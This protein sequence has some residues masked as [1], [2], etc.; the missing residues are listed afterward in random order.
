MSTS[1]TVPGG[2]HL[3][4]KSLSR[5]SVEGE[6][7]TLELKT[8]VNLLV[9][10]PNTGK[11]SWVRA[12][13]YIFG[14]SN[15]PPKALKRNV[16]LKYDRVRAV[17][18]IDGA[19]LLLERGW[20]PDA[21]QGKV[22][23][24]GLSVDQSEFSDLFLQ[25][26]G[27]PVL[28]IPQGNPY[29]ARTWPRLSWRDLYRH[30]YRNE[31]SW[32]DIADRQP[33]S[34]QFASL[35]VLLGAGELV[36]PPDFGNLVDL[37]K[38]KLLLEG[39]KE[40]YISTLEE[41]TRDLVS[42]QEASVA[43]TPDSIARAKERVSAD[44]AS[45]EEQRGR[46]L[47]ALRES[48]D[49]VAHDRQQSRFE[50]VATDLAESR[51]ARDKL[52]TDMLALRQRI[53]ELNRLGS[54]ASGEFAKLG[55]LKVASGILADLKITHCPN[56]DQP[57]SAERLVPENH[58]HVCVQPYPISNST[59]GLERVEFEENQLQSELAELSELLTELVSEESK[60]S[61][62]IRNIDDRIR[63]LESQLAPV[64]RTAALVLP[65]ELTIID[66]ERGQLTEQARQLD[67]VSSAL[68]KRDKLAT[69]IDALNHEIGVLEAAVRSQQKDAP[70]EQLAN[71]FAMHMNEYLNALNLN[72]D[73]NPRWVAG[74]VSARLTDSSLTFFINGNRWGEVVGATNTC[75]FLV[76]YNY[77]LL[78]MTGAPG[79]LYP[80]LCVIDLPANMS[81]VKVMKD[82]EN[83]LIEPF[84]RLLGQTGHKGCQLIAV[85]HAYDNIPNANRISFKSVFAAPEI[86]EPSVGE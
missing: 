83:Y 68:A 55:R 48:V 5:F 34:Q 10:I 37:T 73:G 49:S 8:G 62:A 31:N 4:V 25:K 43:L 27:I 3:L 76:A 66:Q 39:K 17:L 60:A 81:D 19:E 54:V 82:Q 67:R 33:A 1:L 69:S 15:S 28:R 11:S 32:T 41:V 77:A 59:A 58:C 6:E 12:L 64:Q 29:S 44:I 80:G 2:K 53:S 65:P 50:I 24:D 78:A 23:V 71:T 30:I 75:Y 42:I 74:R 63:T 7:E 56:C 26:L 14:D 18:S 16:S 36:F 51:A 35:I 52:T 13:D 20:G 70:L 46:L 57:I 45:L 61:I 86:E 40:Q 84:S 21:V 22:L 72:V 38:Q 79:N 47:S 9:G 85:G